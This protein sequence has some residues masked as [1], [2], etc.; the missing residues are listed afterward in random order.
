MA[1]D[2]GGWSTSR[3][4]R[5][6]PRKECRYPLGG[7]M[8]VPHSH[9]GRFVNEIHQLHQAGFEPSSVPLVA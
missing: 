1:L 6:T 9:S 8:G 4:G 3:P 2:E 5:C 7:R